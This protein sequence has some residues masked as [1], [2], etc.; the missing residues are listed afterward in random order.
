[1]LQYVRDH[2][3]VFDI[4]QNSQTGSIIKVQLSL[5]LKTFEDR[6]EKLA[7]I[8]QQWRQEDEDLISLAG[9]RDEVCDWPF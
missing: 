8:L 7:G 6:T 3:D 9:W 4:H 5:D 2:P 1:V